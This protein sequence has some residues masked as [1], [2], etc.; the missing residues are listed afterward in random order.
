MSVR[1]AIT[2]LLGSVPEFKE[3]CRRDIEPGGRISVERARE[4][5]TEVDRHAHPTT[6]LLRK[7]TG[8][9][10]LLAAVPLLMNGRLTNFCEDFPPKPRMTR[11]RVSKNHRAMGPSWRSLEPRLP[12]THV[13]SS[14]MRNFTPWDMSASGSSI[15]L[16]PA[17]NTSRPAPSLIFRTLPNRALSDATPKSGSSL[18]LSLIHI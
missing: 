3:R 1:S 5:A 4:G 8:A 10:A 18:F 2:L 16:E 17:T 11:A 12:G 7:P 15:R 6:L 9:V 13:S 14:S